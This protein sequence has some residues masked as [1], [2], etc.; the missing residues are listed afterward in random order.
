[1]GETA[2][3]RED[4]PEVAFSFEV[5]DGIDRLMVAMNGDDNGK[6]RNDFDLFLIQGSGTTAEAVCKEDG[7]GQFAFCSIHS[8]PA[9]PWKAVVRRKQGGGLA[10]VVVTQLFKTIAQR[11]P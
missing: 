1:M 9:G 3:L 2:A 4:R 7:P 10:Q 11:T 8:P 5:R 6:G